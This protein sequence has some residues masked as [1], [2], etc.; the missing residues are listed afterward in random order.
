MIDKN[1]IV[2]FCQNLDDNEIG[3]ILILASN[4]KKVIPYLEGNMFDVTASLIT[5]ANMSDDF[6]EILEDAYEYT[7]KE[8]GEE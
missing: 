7:H 6:K 1:E 3:T 5:L 4:G 8:G 2:D